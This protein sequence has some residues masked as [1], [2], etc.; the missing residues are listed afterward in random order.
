M[1]LENLREM[2]EPALILCG[3]AALI[4]ALYFG[5]R[6]FMVTKRIR[7]ESRKSFEIA[8]NIEEAYQRFHDEV[9]ESR[10]RLREQ[11]DEMERDINDRV[12]RSEKVAKSTR[13]RL[14][15]LE[16]YLKEFFEG[17]MKSVFESFDRT[18]TSIL[19]EMK[20]ELLRGVDRIEEIQAVVDSK[21]FAQDRILDGEGSVYRMISE[22]ATASDE[23]PAN[24]GMSLEDELETPEE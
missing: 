3:P 12:E 17:E 7:E 19:E 16:T 15:Q 18:V 10:Q 24:D 20:S 9:T 23:E 13:D 11:F 21:A 1:S 14:I 8:T 5:L 6:F 22:T 2:I 4:L